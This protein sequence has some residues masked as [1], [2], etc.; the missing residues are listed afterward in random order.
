[1]NEKKLMRFIK[2]II[3]TYKDDVS[4]AHEELNSLRNKLAKDDVSPEVLSLIGDIALYLPYVDFDREFLP[5]T[6]EYVKEK[7]EEGKVIKAQ[8]EKSEL[9]KLEDS[10]SHKLYEKLSVGQT[11]Q[12]QKKQELDDISEQQR[13]RNNMTEIKEILSCSS[14]NPEYIKYLAEHL[15]M[16]DPYAINALKNAD[17]GCYGF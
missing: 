17:R 9:K 15:D 10:K 8:Q 12:V 13:I 4:R 14:V 6:K 5:F 2:K 1:M 3:N 7:I 11:Q 16:S